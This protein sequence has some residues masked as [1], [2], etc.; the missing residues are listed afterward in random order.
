MGFYDLE[1]TKQMAKRIKAAG[2][3][4]LLDFITAIRGLIRGNSSSHLPGED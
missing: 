2:L 1:H 3:K 4:I